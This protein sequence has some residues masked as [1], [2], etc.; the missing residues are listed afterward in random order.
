MES[1]AV[2]LRILDHAKRLGLDP[3][4]LTDREYRR[5]A[6]MAQGSVRAQIAAGIA[7][8]ASMAR[9]RVLRLTVLPSVSAENERVCR[10]NSCGAFTGLAG[11]AVA[12][13]A[14]GCSGALLASKWKDPRGRCPKG[15]W[16]NR[17]QPVVKNN[18]GIDVESDEG[19]A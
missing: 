2:Q 10:E 6:I 8:T 1:T 5:L 13:N 12:C 9:T 17:G 7:A 14:C 4:S 11:D 16:S 19:D 15:I 18:H 3:S